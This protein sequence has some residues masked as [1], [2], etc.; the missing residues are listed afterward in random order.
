MILSLLFV[1][2]GV[3]VGLLVTVDALQ[4]Q[5]AQLS[6]LLAG[7]EAAPGQPGSDSHD[8][9][10]SRQ[11]ALVR[12]ARRVGPATVSISA[13]KS[14]V[15]PQDAT[16]TDFFDRFFRGHFP[17]K[18]YREPYQSFGSGVIVDGDG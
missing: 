7:G 2:A 3:T 13:V 14:R 11:T 1:V 9:T 16:D 12:A 10:L 6:T 5:S 15:I 8:I 4:E 17:D 18:V